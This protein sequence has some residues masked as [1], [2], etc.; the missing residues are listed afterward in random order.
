MMALPQVHRVR[1]PNPLEGLTGDA[2]ALDRRSDPLGLGRN[3]M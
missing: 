2:P 1:S 3:M